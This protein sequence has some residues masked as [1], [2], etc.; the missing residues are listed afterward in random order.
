MDAT[1]RLYSVLFNGAKGQSR[2]RLSVIPVSKSYLQRYKRGHLKTWYPPVLHRHKHTTKHTTM[3]PPEFERKTPVSKR[4]KTVSFATAISRIHPVSL[5]M[6]HYLGVLTTCLYT[7]FLFG[8]FFRFS[9]SVRHKFRVCAD[10]CIIIQFI[11]VVNGSFRLH[12]L[13]KGKGN[14]RPRTGK[15]SH[16][17]RRGA[18]LIFNLGAIWS[19]RAGLEGCGKSQTHQQSIPRPSS[20]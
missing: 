17:G 6:H 11:F 14:V 18:P 13:V 4:Q 15:E 8:R 10:I 1:G 2:T 20:T 3:P 9:S 5:Q 7:L 12:G 16:R 19:P